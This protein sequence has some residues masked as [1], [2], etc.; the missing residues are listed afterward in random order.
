MTSMNWVTR[1][2]KLS[3]VALTYY[4]TY[5]CVFD[6]AWKV[7]ENYAFINEQLFSAKFVRT[8]L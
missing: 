5:I 4:R 8:N 3:S 7:N 2:L 6:D 1:S